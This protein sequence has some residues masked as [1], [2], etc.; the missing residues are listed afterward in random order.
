[1]KTKK[2][3]HSLPCKIFFKDLT[4][5]RLGRWLTTHKW[6]AIK[7]LPNSEELINKVFKRCVVM[8]F[9]AKVSSR[10]QEKI[11]SMLEFQHTNKWTT[12]LDKL[13]TSRNLNKLTIHLFNTLVHELIS[14]E[15]EYKLFWTPAYK[16]LSD[17]LSLPI[18]IGCADL[19]SKSSLIKKEV[20]SK[21]LTVTSTVTQKKSDSYQLSTSSI[22]DKWIKEVIKPKKNQSKKVVQD[23]YN[24]AISN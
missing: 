22:A 19:H 9:L 7:H 14:K 13:I 10:A 5:K 15:K 4:S 18:E 2:K 8:I 6:M 20:L 17:R 11:F 1:M 23:N 12:F 16:V 3:K 21:Y 24:K